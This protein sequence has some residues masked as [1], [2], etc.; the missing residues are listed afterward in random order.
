MTVKNNWFEI[1]SVVIDKLVHSLQ[2]IQMSNSC[3][4]IPFNLI[5]A[6]IRGSVNE[7]QVL[8]TKLNALKTEN[9]KLTKTS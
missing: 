3:P 4:Q 1:N 2:E 9:D 5:F 6:M 7:I 8:Q